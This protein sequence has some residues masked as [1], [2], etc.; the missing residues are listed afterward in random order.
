MSD[1]GSFEIPIE[2]MAR[3]YN[4]MLHSI[5]NSKKPGLTIHHAGGSERVGIFSESEFKTLEKKTTEEV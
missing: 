5:M 1:Q 2:V 4:T 3:I